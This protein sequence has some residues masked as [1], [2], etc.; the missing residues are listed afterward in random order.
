MAIGRS[1]RSQLLG[2]IILVAILLLG[3][4]F[5][6]AYEEARAES[7]QVRA[8]ALELAQLTAVNVFQFLRER[9]MFLAEVAKRPLIQA[10]DPENCDPFLRDFVQLFPQFAGIGLVDVSGQA[11]C[12]GTLDP[13][14]PLPNIGDRPYF[15]ELLA[16]ESFAVGNVQQ[17]RVTGRWVVVLAYPVRNEVG[18]LVGALILPLDLAYFQ[19]GLTEAQFKQDTVI[20]IIDETG[21]VV[22]RS[23]DAA[24]LVGR[25]IRGTEVVDR[26]LS[27]R[28][29]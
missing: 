18:V 28:P 4:I 15:Q 22:A 13:Q 20:T 5:Y 10:V 25:Q 16:T 14:A 23:G 8:Q 9:E 24:D 27:G 1:I 7:E 29:G 2:I 17:G 6:T 26:V 3:A 21:T 19:A 12:S 11:V